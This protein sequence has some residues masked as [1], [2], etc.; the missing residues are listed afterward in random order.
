VVL[1][2]KPI[3]SEAQTHACVTIGICAYN[4]EKNIGPLLHSILLQKIADPFEIVV[5]SDGS[6]DST[7]SIVREIA[8][9]N[10]SVRLTRH[11]FRKGRSEAIDTLLRESSGEVVV[12]VSADTQLCDGSIQR[13]IDVFE[14]PRVGM[15][16]AR[17]VPLNDRQQLTDRVGNLSFRIHHRLSARLSSE[18]GIRHATGDIVAIRKA[19]ITDRPP[20]CIN[21]DEFLAIN[22][23]RMGFKVHY[24]PFSLCKTAM[25][26]NA[27]DYVNQRRR[28]VYGHL[29]VGEMLGEY[30]TVLECVVTKRPI[31]A[32]SVI[33]Q[34]MA[35]QPGELIVLFSSILLELAVA[36]LVL[37]DRI[38]N[39]SHYPWKIIES[40]K[41]PL[42]QNYNPTPTKIEA[43]HG[44]LTQA[45]Q[46][47][48]RKREVSR[49]RRP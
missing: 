7:D 45:E 14:E 30:P 11:L 3:L 8:D 16:W 21:D 17:L 19:A 46:A 28:W 49:R 32:M 22:A 37:K 12:V 24:V 43:A 31:L 33:V 26:T 38:L 25:P 15:C 47:I 2:E 13:M 42:Y 35:A 23:A 27:V 1:E 29:Q 39:I 5:V 41:R 6:T 20:G 36:L 40:T 48:T 4:E 34:E 9:L 18:G 10:P 44:P